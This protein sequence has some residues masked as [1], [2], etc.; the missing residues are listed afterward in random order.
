MNQQQLIVTAEPITPE[1]YAPFGDLVAA[2]YGRS[3]VPA[4][5]GTAKRYNHLAGLENLRPDRASLNVC[6]YRCAPASRVPVEIGLLERHAFSTQIFVPM[7][8]TQ[9][10]L[11]VVA[12]P[13][14]EIVPSS[15][16][17]FL[18]EGA[19]AISYRPG[20]W[21]HPM[22][23]L[24]RESDFACFV[25]ECGDSGDCEVRNLPAPCAVRLQG[26]PK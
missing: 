10:Y 9:R 16:R 25:W 26:E 8:G 11:I 19:Q 21:H 23:A 13:G 24:D 15:M 12:Q 1:G 7:P 18:V 17:A 5:M 20:V 3:H 6:Q 4:N 14:A 22:I 2:G